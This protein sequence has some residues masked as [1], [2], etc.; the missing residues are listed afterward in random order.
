MLGMQAHAWRT[1]VSIGVFL[2]PSTLFVEIGSLTELELT[3]R[4]NNRAVNLQDLP[5]LPPTHGDHKH[6]LL[7]LVFCGMLEA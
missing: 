3:D 1:E 4:L 6:A 7:H 5:S 2:S